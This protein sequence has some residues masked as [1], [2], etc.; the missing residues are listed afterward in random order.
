MAAVGGVV[1]VVSRQAWHLCDVVAVSP[2]HATIRRRS[3]G[4]TA[5]V[6]HRKTRAP[7]ESPTCEIGAEALRRHN[8]YI[9][10]FAAHDIKAIE[11]ALHPNVVVYI[12]ENKVN[13]GR[14]NVLPSYAADFDAGKVVTESV[15]A[16]FSTDCTDAAL[17]HATVDVEL[18]AEV[19]GGE[20][21]VV[22]VWYRYD[23]HWRQVRHDIEIINKW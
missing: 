9:A 11:A 10:A 19:P 17:Y 18:T 14:A 20:Q 12:G 13:D 15:R 6:P 16:V 7:A 23:E 8:A 4:K 1:E 5:D 22:R 2:T 3:D 21:T